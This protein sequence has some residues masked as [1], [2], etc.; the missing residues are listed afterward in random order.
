[1]GANVICVIRNLLMSGDCCLSPLQTEEGSDYYS[2]TPTPVI[3]W[4]DALLSGSQPKH[5]LRTCAVQAAMLRAD[6]AGLF[7]TGPQRL[8]RPM[9]ADSQIVSGQIQFFGN[10]GGRLPF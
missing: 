9:E 4:E 8:A 3:F 1:V 10:G 7:Q 2:R 6:P 5:S